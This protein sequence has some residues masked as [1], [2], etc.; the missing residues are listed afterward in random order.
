MA[1][2]TAGHVRG[3]AS[4]TSVSAS[5]SRHRT[6]AF[7]LISGRVSVRTI[8][9]RAE[10]LALFLFSSDGPTM[11]TAFALLLATILGAGDRLPALAVAPLQ[12]TVRIR[13]FSEW[14][15]TGWHTRNGSGT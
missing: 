10:Q 2:K 13:M 5:T 6:S 3:M 1:L 15:G 12:S 7:T 14:D 4:K 9:P 11:Q 8:R